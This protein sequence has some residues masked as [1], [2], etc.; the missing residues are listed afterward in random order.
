[1]G[2][3]N[4]Y[5]KNLEDAIVQTDTVKIFD[6]LLTMG[7]EMGA[8][9]IHI[10][11]FE[12]FSRIR[13]RIDGVLQEIIQY[14]KNIQDSVIAKFKIESGQMRPDEKR[15][16]QDARVSTVTLTNKE[17]DLRAN[18]LPTVRGEKLVMRIVDKSKK[19]PPLEV[20]GIEG[21]NNELLYKSITMPN[22]IV[23][24]TG[25]TGSGKSTTL[26]AALNYI[27]TVDV[28]ITTYEDPVENKSDGLNQSQVRSDIGYTFAQ[29]LRAALRQDPDIIMV[30]EI[31]DEETLEMGMEAAMTGHLVFST[32]H[33]NSAAE[34]ITRI[35][36]MGAQPYMISGTFNLVMAQRLGRTN[37]SHCFQEVNV[38][39]KF[40]EYYKNAKEVLAG[41]QK[42][43]IKREVVGRGIDQEKW[44]KFVNEGVGYVGTGKD[45]ETGDVC[46]Q[47]GGS[48]YKGR[49]GIY[50]FMEFDEEIK[51]YLTQGKTAFE[52]EKIAL[53]RGMINLERDGI[54]KVIGGK[55]SLEEIYR[56][57]KH[58]EN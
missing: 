8:S 48:G 3:I 32:I 20:M 5:K 55:T 13:M 36:N 2:D 37:C 16:P 40:P 51:N 45:P 53:D 26:Y 14:P 1:M 21:L 12:N 39:E 30:G 18:T 17:I 7:V 56:L 10:E 44:S 50:E 31:R 22:G 23:L 33:A 35:I 57:T 19:V 47:C 15:L 25:P 43:H 38:K 54:F 52:I 6:N 58:R 27:N 4:N 41:M 34:T 11:P 29:G 24:T 42:D 28:N 9:D 46:P 49:I